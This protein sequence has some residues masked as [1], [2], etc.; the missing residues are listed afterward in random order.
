[1][2]SD[3]DSQLSRVW[4]G[5]TLPEDAEV[6]ERLVTEEVLP[7]ME[8]MK[9]FLG[10]QM[11][12]LDRSEETE[13]LVITEWDSLDAVKSFAGEDYERT[14]IPYEAEQLLSRFDKGPL[15]YRRR[16]KVDAAQRS[17]ETR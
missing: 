8:E 3:H 17:G 9:G 7:A 15:H 2:M 10:A 12:R 16:Y 1:M 5:W 14:S 11:M 4:H 6:Y 13:F